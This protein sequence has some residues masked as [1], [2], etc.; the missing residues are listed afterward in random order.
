MA[1]LRIYFRD[2]P[3]IKTGR[4]KYDMQD[5]KEQ[6][7]VTTGLVDTFLAETTGLADKLSKKRSF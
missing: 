5:H 7:Q 2:T 1:H 6:I 3:R 4:V